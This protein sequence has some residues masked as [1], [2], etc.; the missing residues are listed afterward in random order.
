ML[1]KPLIILATRTPQRISAT[2]T[3]ELSDSK[4]RAPIAYNSSMRILF[5]G[6]TRF[7]GLAMAREAL[8]RG[9]AVDLFHR[10]ATSATGL[11]GATHLHGDRSA[12]TSSL[13]RGQWDA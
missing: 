11:E 2:A 3:V 12:D 7:V 10:G 9:H 6:G 8:R 1:G 5:I 13:A 4:A